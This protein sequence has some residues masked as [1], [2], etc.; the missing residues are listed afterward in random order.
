LSTP[1]SC[2][3]RFAKARRLYRFDVARAFRR[4]CL[5]L[6]L[7]I[8]AAP[9]GAQAQKTDVLVLLNGDRITGEVKGLSRGK[10][11]YN[12]DDAG[13]PSIEWV[14]VRRLTSSHYF[15]VEV[16]SGAK[17]FGRL[18][19]ADRDGVI[20]VKLD[21]ADTL[22]VPSV[23]RISTLDAAFLQRVTAYLDLGFSY[24]KANSATTFNM[25][26]EVKYRGPKYGSSIYVE[27]YAQGQEDVPTTTRNTA[28]LQGTYYLP[29]R[30]SIVGLAQTEQNDELNLALR[31]TLGGGASRVFHQSNSGELTAAAGVVVAQERFHPAEGDTNAAEEE[32]T[33]LEGLLYGQWD[34]YRY[35]TPKLD[36]STS[37]SLYPSLSSLGRV[38]GELAMRIKYEVF[39]DFNVGL[40][41]TDTFDS[42]PPEETASKNDFIS[43]LTIGWSYRR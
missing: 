2:E 13:R 24:A 42:E 36:F 22:A 12:T 26:A 40:K 25:D 5:L 18:A 43:S 32:Q 16:A 21:R 30:W 29:D 15:E 10:L 7:G 8:A 39:R 37:L 3:R 34:A 11:D 20:V 4:S 9:S 35:D 1:A 38:R 23:V 6:V 14:K 28:E 27:S 19:E 17:Y 33:N 41:F 31:F